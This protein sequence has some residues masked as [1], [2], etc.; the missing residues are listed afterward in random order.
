MIQFRRNLHG[1]EAFQY[2]ALFQELQGVVVTESQQDKVVWSPQPSSGFSVKACYDWWR[3]DRQQQPEIASK[4]KA[5]WGPKIPLKIW[6]LL[7]EATDM[8]TSFSSLQS[9]WEA[10]KKMKTP[11]DRSV[12]AKVSQSFI[13]AVCWAVWLERVRTTFT[14]RYKM[15][16]IWAEVNGPITLEDGTAQRH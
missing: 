11:G 12:V 13:P 14:M 8:D 3:R 15:V 6:S 9:M 5:I 1:V 10:V 7:S 16:N 4:A 2:S